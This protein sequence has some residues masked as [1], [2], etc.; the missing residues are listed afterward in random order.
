M[1]PVGLI[2]TS[3]QGHLATVGPVRVSLRTDD[4]AFTETM[5]ATARLVNDEHPTLDGSPAP[6]V[7][8]VAPW[9]F[10]PAIVADQ[11]GHIDAELSDY[12][13]VGLETWFDLSPDPRGWIKVL[14]FRDGGCVD[15]A[16]DGGCLECAWLARNEILTLFIGAEA[17]DL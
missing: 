11:I 2:A 5:D 9:A 14:G 4:G 12:A 3:A 16:A 1:D 13:H 10:P 15:C 8:D 7:A 6:F 17:D